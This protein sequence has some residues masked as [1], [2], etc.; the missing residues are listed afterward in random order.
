MA[1]CLPPSQSQGPAQPED[2]A[3]PAPLASGLPTGLPTGSTI[4]DIIEVGYKLRLDSIGA[5]VALMEL[6]AQK[7]WKYDG[8]VADSFFFMRSPS[9]D[10]ATEEKAAAAFLGV[11]C[12]ALKDEKTNQ[13]RMLSPMLL[14][15][16]KSYHFWPEVLAVATEH[17]L[18]EAAKVMQKKVK[19][20]LSSDTFVP[21]II[22]SLARRAGAVP[23]PGCD[24][25]ESA[26]QSESG[27]CVAVVSEYPHLEQFNP[28]ARF[29]LTPSCRCLKQGAKSELERDMGTIYVT[30]TDKEVGKKISKGFC[31]PRDTLNNPV[32]DYFENAI[33]PLHERLRASNPLVFEST[34]GEKEVSSPEVLRAL[35]SQDVIQPQHLKKCL[36]E[37]VC[38][39]LRFLRESPELA[40]L[41]EVLKLKPKK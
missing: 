22:A 11:L 10:K 31:E 5:H 19:N 26:A 2:L 27:E 34:E 24:P 39:I 14:D 6:C 35:Y 21:C 36:T 20:M 32:L 17:T 1:N 12:H 37:E 4:I 41:N 18:E 28:A 23:R 15:A 16:E 33:F 8:V 13:L 29:F 38:A 3:G 40:V 25:G 7:G 9:V 30:D